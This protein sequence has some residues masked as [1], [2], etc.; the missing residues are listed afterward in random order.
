MAENRNL[1][2][3]WETWFTRS[4]GGEPR[5]RIRDLTENATLVLNRAVIAGRSEW[6]ATVRLA[7][8]S[9]DITRN[10][11]LEPVPESD[12]SPWPTMQAAAESKA[13][14]WLRELAG[15][16]ASAIEALDGGAS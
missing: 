6:T 15:E 10:F 7:L 5:A 8:K 3:Q 2:G 13:S 1:S 4:P 9:H 11:D 16:T 12:I 14:D